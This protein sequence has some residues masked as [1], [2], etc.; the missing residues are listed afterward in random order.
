MITWQNYD[1]GY[2][3]PDPPEHGVYRGPIIDVVT[4]KIGASIAEYPVWA[5]YEDGSIW[6]KDVGLSH[7]K[8][9]DGVLPE[10]IKEVL[11]KR[12][13][14]IACAESCT[15]GLVTYLLSTIPGISNH[16]SEGIV[17]YS[18]EAKI[19]YLNVSKE[20]LAR[21]GAVSEQVAYEMAVGIALVAKTD[22][23]LSTTGIAGPGGA[24]PTKPV[25]TVFV[26]AWYR[27]DA[28]VRRLDLQGNRTDIQK[29]SALSLFNI[30]LELLKEL[31]T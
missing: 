19:K 31:D 12:N 8:H 3:H 13:L 26:G 20:S 15:G 7:K 5:T 2:E 24:T 10:Q 18:N 11:E 16:L 17:T 14:T 23:G 29:N 4:K 21:F 9:I 22:L 27:G 6:A 25:G 30:T 28:I 1:P